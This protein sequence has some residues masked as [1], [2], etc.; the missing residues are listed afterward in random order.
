MTVPAV[1][2]GKC[3]RNMEQREPALGAPPPGEGGLEQGPPPPKTKFSGAVASPHVVSP[4]PSSA[5][6]CTAYAFTPDPCRALPHPLAP[7]PH[8]PKPPA[9]THSPPHRLRIAQNVCRHSD[10]GPGVKLP[11]A[12]TARRRGRRPPALVPTDPEV[13]P[14]AEDAEPER[15]PPGQSLTPAGAVLRGPLPWA[16]REGQSGRRERGHCRARRV[17]VPLVRGAKRDA[18][19]C[20]RWAAVGPLPPA[21]PEMLTAAVRCRAVPVHHQPAVSPRVMSNR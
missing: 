14:S 19:K 12:P 9:G 13:P 15:R 18:H 6:C 1:C 20:V 8:K 17:H 2:H 10:P 3:I 5:R 11:Q 21:V 4:I 16:A 7:G